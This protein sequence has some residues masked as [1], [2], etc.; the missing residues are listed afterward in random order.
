VNRSQ[1][2]W[3]QKQNKHTSFIF[4][5]FFPLI[6]T[7]NDIDITFAHLHGYL[8]VCIHIVPRQK[9][10]MQKTTRV[11]CSGMDSN[12]TAKVSEWVNEW[13]IWLQSILFCATGNK[14]SEIYFSGFQL[15]FNWLI[16][17]RSPTT[18]LR[19]ARRLPVHRFRQHAEMARNCQHGNA[20]TSTVRQ[21]RICQC[22]IVYVK[23]HAS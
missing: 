5:S 23:H 21:W 12:F 9:E 4:I 10:T 6:L 11:V 17:D 8:S 20:P 13:S 14:C 19:V 16:W 7:T 18:K 22:V 15:L 1:I 2:C 3:K